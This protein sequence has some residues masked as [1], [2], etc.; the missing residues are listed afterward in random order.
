[1]RKISEEKMPDKNGEEVFRGFDDDILYA[2][3][4]EDEESKDETEDDGKSK[5][6]DLETKT[7]E[8]SKTDE[9]SDENAKTQEELEAEEQ[10]KKEEQHRRNEEFKAK[11]LA[12][13]K[14]EREE[15]ERKIREEAETKGKL[16]LLKQNPYTHEKIEAEEDLKI[17]EIQKKLEEEGLNPVDDLPK[18]L[19][20]LNRKERL[21]KEQEEK[22]KSEQEEKLKKDVEDFRKVYPNVNIEEL[23]NNDEY[24]KY[25]EKDGRWK[26]WTMI[27]VYEG[28]LAEKERNSAKKKEAMA[29][30]KA[31][32]V[33]K[34]MTK[35][36]SSKSNGGKATPDSYMDM[37][38]EEYLKLQKENSGD[39]F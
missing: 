30:E 20:E 22:A 1:M 8:D 33:S 7:E 18:R 6:E 10:R 37:T 28:Y 29:D 32:E 24:I 9:N 13:E 25:G 12:K 19:A 35:V 26:R 11:R 36:P 21:Q 23:A 14:K 31:D 5:G 4:F 3:D 27:E 17:Y 15:R 38:D 39:F 2:D 16:S 34:K